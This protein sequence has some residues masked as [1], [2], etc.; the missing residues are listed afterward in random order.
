M[1][2]TTMQ[3]MTVGV[4]SVEEEYFHRPL[5]LYLPLLGIAINWYL[6]AQLLWTDLTFLVFFLS[7]VASFYFSF[8]YNFSMGNNGGGDAYNSCGL[9]IHTK[10]SVWGADNGVDGE[11][12]S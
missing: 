11:K 3:H 12:N 8:G 2:C 9:S 7:L 5:V 6:V 10:P 4:V 1:R